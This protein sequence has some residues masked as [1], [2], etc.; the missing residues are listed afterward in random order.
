MNKSMF[1]F[2]VII[3]GN[4]MHLAQMV[5][6]P[7]KLLS[8]ARFLVI[9]RTVAYRAHPSMEFSRQE[10]WSGLPFL[11]PGDLLDS[12]IES[13]SPALQADALPSEPPGK[14]PSMQETGVQF[15]GLED[16]LLK[17]MATH[18]SILAWGITW[19]SLVGYTHGVAKIWTR[20][21]DFEFTFTFITK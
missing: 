20:L 5:S 15:L 7:V 10:Y 12:G 11:S 4:V 17:G 6:E 2:D 1:I 13:R 21:S 8:R 16:P 14:L 18:C 9:P 3:N 19:S